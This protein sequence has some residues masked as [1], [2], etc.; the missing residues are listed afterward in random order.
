MTGARRGTSHNLIYKETGWPKLSERRTATKLMN[1]IKIANNDTPHYLHN[2]LPPKTRQT[3]PMS[4]CADNYRLIKT[5][6]EKASYP[7]W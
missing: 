4:R 1:L 6:T 7:Q 3:R 2:L 5:R